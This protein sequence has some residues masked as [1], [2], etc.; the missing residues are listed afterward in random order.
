[1]RAAFPL[2]C[3]LLVCDSSSDPD[4]E[5]DETIRYS[6]LL[7][8][9]VGADGLVTTAD[10]TREDDAEDGEEENEKVSAA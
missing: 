5:V 2:C 3:Q 6:E 4:G 8:T 7:H 9:E 10:G 1:V